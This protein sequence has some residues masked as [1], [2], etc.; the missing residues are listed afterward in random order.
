MIGYRISTSNGKVSIT[1][2]L[3][4]SIVSE[5]LDYLLDFLLEPHPEDFRVFWD[6]D[7]E[8]SH[9]LRLLDKGRLEILFRQCRT[10]LSPYGI[11][12]HPGKSLKINK[13]SYR[14]YYYNLSQYFPEDKNPENPAKAKQ[15]GEKLLSVL[16]AI[17]ISP[18]RLS[19]PV[20]LFDEIWKN[21]PMPN[22]TSLPD[23]VGEL[24]YQASG[25]HWTEAHQL[26]HFNKVY[27]YDIRSSY[28]S[29]AMNLMDHR[30]GKWIES[31]DKINDAVYGFFYA[32]VNI[33][34]KVSP[35]SYADNSGRLFNPKGSWYAYLTKI[36]LE[37]I[38]YLDLGRYK[39]ITG[40]WWVP[41]KKV[42]PLEIILKRMFRQRDRG[43][44]MDRILKK[45]MVGI[46][47]KF[48]Q[49]NSDGTF[50]FTYNPVWGRTIEAEISCKVARFIYENKLVKELIHVS[51]DGVLVKKPVDKSM[52]G[53]D[54]GE[55]KADSY[56]PALVVSSGSLFYGKKRPH[57]LTYDEA[58]GMVKDKPNASRW[59]Q[60]IQRRITLG[61]CLLSDIDLGKM[62]SV[63]TGFALTHD[64][65]RLYKS[66]PSNGQELLEGQYMSEPLP[67]SKLTK[68]ELVPINDYE[69]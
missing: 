49:I 8:V 5:N 65:D 22:W 13:G 44:L 60:S 50:S 10:W 28:P 3:G 18:S 66:F 56:G 61:D 68:P 2:S 29:A 26:G 46:Y 4:G 48:L 55:W 40:W 17:K 43:S 19:S 36:E 69:E 9:L 12:Y 51:T 62:R 64:H 14:A 30:Y 25:A 32:K 41:D 59:E 58:V 39:I 1:N 47:G 67:A 20:A 16:E 63:A 52:L 21:I 6:I 38:E 37:T 34:A 54:I 11:T 7:E 53:W 27:D 15:Y 45:A 33:K 57:Q 31:K 23:D 35:I 24:A 42:F